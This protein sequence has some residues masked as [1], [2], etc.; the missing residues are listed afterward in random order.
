MVDVRLSK[1]PSA[2]VVIQAIQGR[3][4]APYVVHFNTAPRILG[5]G[6][7]AVVQHRRLE[8]RNS[9]NKLQTQEE[10]LNSSRLSSAG[11]AGFK[12]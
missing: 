1:I 9:V 4:V 3:S 2:T 5:C 7:V 8:H 6:N 11:T 10:T 12:V